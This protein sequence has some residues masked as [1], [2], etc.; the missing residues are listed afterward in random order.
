[1]PETYSENSDSADHATPEAQIAALNGQLARKEEKLKARSEALVTATSEIQKLRNT[2][3]ENFQQT[4]K[5]CYRLLNAFDPMLGNQA[6]SVVDI[7]RRMGKS[8]S[9]TEEERKA[10][11]AAA[12]LHDLGL[13]SF[14]R[15]LVHK[16]FENASTLTENEKQ[17]LRQHPAKGQQ[18]VYFTDDMRQTGEIIRSHHERFDGQGYPDNFAGETI[19]WA[20]RCLAIAIYYVECG[21][22]KTLAL[23]DILKQSGTTFD[24]EAVRLFFKMTQA[25][26]LPPQVKEV[27][28]GELAPGMCLAD[29]IY[30]NAGLLLFPKGIE[31]TDATIAKVQKH[32]MLGA[33]TQRFL[34]FS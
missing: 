29:D 1:M 23:E 8:E 31:L 34:V 20:S 22:P 32:N 25:D 21:Q 24:P 15:S 18:L 19:P 11:L 14:S 7:C 9:F 6:C 5:F 3:D 16:M 33:V 30:N 26:S 10:F 12:W 13:L 28:V 27:M 17:A 2:V 4:V